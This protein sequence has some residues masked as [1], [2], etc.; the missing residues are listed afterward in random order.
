MEVRYGGGRRLVTPHHPKG[1]PLA[2]ADE[3]TRCE[4]ADYNPSRGSR[5][6]Q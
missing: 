5:L 3:H 4:T 6:R 2:N 1:R